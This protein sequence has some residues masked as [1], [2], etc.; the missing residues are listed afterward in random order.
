MF[1]KFIQAIVITFILGWIG[2][3]GMMTP[4]APIATT[5]SSQPTVQIIGWNLLDLVL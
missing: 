1:N 2:G 4:T 3:K 5:N